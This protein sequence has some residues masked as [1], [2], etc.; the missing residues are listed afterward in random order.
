MILNLLSE[1]VHGMIRECEVANFGDI[2][3][4]KCRV[5]S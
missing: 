1:L 5:E 3:V 2:Q 4:T